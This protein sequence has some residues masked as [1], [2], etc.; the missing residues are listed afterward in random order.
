MKKKAILIFLICMITV[1]FGLMVSS[2]S[3]KVPTD[4]LVSKKMTKIPIMDGQLDDIWHLVNNLEIPVEVADYSLFGEIN[5]GKKYDVT[6]RSMYTDSDFYMFVQWTGDQEV[7]N[8]LATWYF[9]TDAGKWVQKPSKGSNKNSQAAYEDKFAFLWEIQSD[10]FLRDGGIIFCHEDYKHTN[11]PDELMDIWHW[12][13]VRSAPVHQ[14]D[15]KKLVFKDEEGGGSLFN[16]RKNDEGSGSYSNNSQTLTIRGK[17]TTLPLYWVPGKA[18]YSFIMDEDFTARKIVDMDVNM[19]MID[20]DGTIL[21]KESFL[22]GSDILI[23]GIKGVKPATESRGDVTVYEFYDPAAHT[24]NLEIQ[25]KLNTGNDDDVQ[26]DD[27]S[28]MYNFS[29]AV[30]NNSSITHA[31]PE[32]INGKAYSLVFR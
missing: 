26:F 1:A 15:D 23:P 12:K 10:N 2:C 28:K 27:M 4:T 32:G 16:G 7:S 25:R 30:F 19:N 22:P 29:I 9:S 5:L 31:T 17:K 18:N 8:E 24:W 13:L 14:L 11:Y 6:L 21:A 3:G 20:E